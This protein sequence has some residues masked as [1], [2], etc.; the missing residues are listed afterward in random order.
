MRDDMVVIK[1]K[2]AHIRDA[3]EKANQEDK[4]EKN[5]FKELFKSIESRLEKL[6]PSNSDHLNA[7][8]DTAW[9][10]SLDFFLLEAT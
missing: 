2:L 8:S 7:S 9:K 5:A 3:Q 1:K 4:K 6:E 10:A